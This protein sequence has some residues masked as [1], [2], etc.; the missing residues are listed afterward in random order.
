MN[1]K[2][3]ESKKEIAT[4]NLSILQNAKITIGGKEMAFPQI[5][6]VLAKQIGQQHGDMERQ[7]LAISEL[8]KTIGEKGSG[9]VAPLANAVT[10]DMAKEMVEVKKEINSV[11]SGL[12]V[13]YL[14]IIIRNQNN[15]LPE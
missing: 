9:L 1:A 6:D 4:S 5:L 2:L 7:A 12:L 3:E 11:I 14:Q 8:H 10:K 13:I 15:H